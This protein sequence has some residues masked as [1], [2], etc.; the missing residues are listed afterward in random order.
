[1]S[2]GIQTCFESPFGDFELQRYPRSR[3]E[4]LQAWDAA[5]SYLLRELAEQGLPEAESRVLLLNDS[6]GA[7]ACSLNAWQPLSSGDSWIAHEAALQNLR[8]NGLP[9]LRFADALDEV[10]ER[11]DL[12]LMRLPKSLAFLQWQL[13]RVRSLL[14]PGGRLLAGVMAKYLQRSQVELMERWIGAADVSLAW[15]KARLVRCQ[16]DPELVPPVLTDPPGYPLENTPFALKGQANVFSRGRL[17]IGTRLLLE[18]IPKGVLDGEV[19]DLGCGD[20][21]VGLVAAWRNPDARILFRDESYMAV[22]SA[23]ENYLAAGLGNPA[24]FEVGDALDGLEPGSLQLVLCNPPFHQQQ[25]VGDQVAR[26]MFRQSHKALQPGERL[27][28]VGNR[29]LGYH[30]TLKRLFGNARLL[31]SDRKFVVLES[32]KAR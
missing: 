13:A 21:V 29:H 22:A 27:I 8:D 32:R 6:C 20:G 19:A 24:R 17:D 1:M 10:D 5:D 12:V 28:I 2:S 9:E 7:L 3:R 14:K 26:R 16:L 23:R 15:K 25:A 11:F 30:V 4:T 18:Q 31:S